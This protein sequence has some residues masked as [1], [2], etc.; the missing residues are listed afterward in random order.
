[1]D[2]GA[3]ERIGPRLHGL[4]NPRPAFTVLLVGCVAAAVL[5]GIAGGLLRVG[6]AV[7]TAAWLPR[8]ALA[9]AALMIGGFLGTVIAIERVVAARQRAAWTGPVASGFAALALLAGAPGLAAALLVLASAVFVLVNLLLLKRQPAAHTAVLLASAAAWFTGNVLLALGAATAAVLPWWF[10]FLVLT[11]AAERLEMTRLMRRRPAAQQA[12]YVVL[13]AIV[14]GA[15]A[16]GFAPVAG[17]VLFGASLAALAAWLLTFDIARR[18][19]RAPGLTRYMA[20]CLL[21]GYIWLAVSGLAWA[22]TALGFPARDAA[23]H[24][25]GLGFIVSMIMGHAPVILPAVA[26]VKLQFGNF[27]YLP[28]AALHL[29]LL[30]RLAGGAFTFRLRAD[31]ALGNALAIA[32]FAATV[33][34]AAL[35]WRHAQRPRRIPS[36]PT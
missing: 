24:A 5:A 19:V 20:V 1:M 34:G 15:V 18:T 31:G 26:R 8:A 7:T 21:A 2:T 29:T 4:V 32:L 3:H 27:F 17:G 13:A 23:L 14:L 28:L 22:A 9:H 25:L 12:L 30:L 36:D 35:A 16:C 33:V 11:I 10:A 6:V